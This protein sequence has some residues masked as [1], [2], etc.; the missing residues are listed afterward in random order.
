[1]H[2][3]LAVGTMP[4]Q[5]ILFRCQSMPQEHM[6]EVVYNL[7]G[8]LLVEGYG[9]IPSGYRVNLGTPEGGGLHYYQLSGADTT[10]ATRDP[11]RLH[12]LVPP[13]PR[14]QPNYIHNPLQ[15]LRATQEHLHGF[16]HGG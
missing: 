8:L 16:S 13:S 2:A 9:D 3:R 7:M 14:P 4:Q 10:H 15:H 1:V 5:Y 12:P 6:C 11:A